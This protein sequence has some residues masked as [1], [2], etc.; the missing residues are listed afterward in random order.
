MY[1][2][3]IG[4]YIVFLLTLLHC[5]AAFAQTDNHLY[6]LAQD[7]GGKSGNIERGNLPNISPDIESKTDTLSALPR[8]F[9]NRFRITGNTVLSDEELLKITTSY[10]N[11]E[12]SFEE[13]QSLRQELTLYYVNKGYINSGVTIPDQPV[14]EGVITLK[15]V[16]GVLSQIEV[17]GNKRIRSGYIISRLQLAGGP[18]VNIFELQKAFQ[19]LQ[20]D[21]RIKR[22]NAQFSPGIQPGESI[23]KVRVEEE[24]PFSAWLEVNNDNS[25][26]I[27]EIGVDLHFIHQNLTGHGDSLVGSLGITEGLIDFDVYYAMPINSRDTTLKFQI[28]KSETTVI[29]KPFENLNIQS[30]S[31]TYGITLSHPFYRTYTRTITLGVTGE[32]RSS[33]TSLLG[34]NFSFSSGV[35]EGEADVTVIRFFQE[36][37][38]KNQSQVIAVRS[39]LSLGIDTFNATINESAPDG[40]FISWLGQFQWIRRIGDSGNQIIF[41]T[42]IQWANDPLLP[43]EKFSVGGVSSVRGYRK[44]R[45]VRDNGLA[46]SLEFRFPVIKDKQGAGTMHLAPF[47]DYGRSWNTETDTPKPKN[48]SSAGLELTWM[49]TK[50]INL[51]LSWGMPFRNFDDTDEDLQDKGIHFSITGRLL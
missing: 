39:T 23:L 50:K 32:L 13:L 43:I 19:L 18:P 47:V 17:D 31:L 45:L 14:D 26:S 9:V 5:P 36:W 1:F 2:A 16:E 10:E 44:N 46:A 3:A 25:P 34:R 33:E 20:Q 22:I 21:P 38:E 51:Q 12:I 8:V 48:I 35:E 6:I 40:E 41:R 4:F 49:I 27:G 7:Q 30:K 24:N 28:R 37:L 15:V 11:R 29:E 42:D